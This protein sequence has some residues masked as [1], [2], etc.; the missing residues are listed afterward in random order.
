MPRAA[1]F[2]STPIFLITR[3]FFRFFPRATA[4]SIMPQASSQLTRRILLAPSMS[5]T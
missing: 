4:R 5:L 2:S 1:D 3:L